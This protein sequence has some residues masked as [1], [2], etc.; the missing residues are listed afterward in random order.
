MRPDSIEVGDTVVID[1]Y[2]GRD[3]RKLM[4]IKR[5]TLDDGAVFMLDAA[6]AS[7]YQEENQ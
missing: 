1:G 3:G 4:S 5:M 2:L 7:E 6:A